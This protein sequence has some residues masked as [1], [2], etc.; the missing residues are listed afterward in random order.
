MRDSANPSS[1]NQLPN[2]R[3]IN[4]SSFESWFAILNSLAL[5]SLSSHRFHPLSP[6]LSTAVR[7]KFFSFSVKS[8]EVVLCQNPKYL[9]G[10]AFSHTV[11]SLS[12]CMGSSLTKRIK[13]WETSEDGTINWVCF[14][15]RAGI[16]ISCSSC[17]S[18]PITNCTRS[19]FFWSDQL[20]TTPQILTLPGPAGTTFDSTILRLSKRLMV[21]FPAP[22]RIISIS[23]PCPAGFRFTPCQSLLWKSLSITSF[24]CE[25]LSPNNLPIWLDKTWA[26][27]L[28]QPWLKVETALRS[29]SGSFPA[30][31]TSKELL[32]KVTILVLPSASWIRSVAIF[33]ASSIPFQPPT[34][35]PVKSIQTSMDRPKGTWLP[36]KG[37]FSGVKAANQWEFFVLFEESEKEWWNARMGMRV[38]AL[39]YGMPCEPIWE[40]LRQGQSTG[41]RVA[42]IQ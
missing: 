17:T 3:I 40:A 32:P 35:F 15:L 27:P 33:W 4:S 13:A 31:D 24:F 14:E 25:E 36:E 16:I 6:A 2:P 20:R 21:S 26:S 5:S 28:L 39:F 12:N 18:P 7:K 1:S 34:A 10:G 30:A 41:Q 19:V 29:L 42:Q 8:S 23:I 38:F 11:R 9:G 22:T 37:E